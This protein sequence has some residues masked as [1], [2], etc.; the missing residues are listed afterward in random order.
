M[1]VESPPPEEEEDGEPLLEPMT[2]GAWRPAAGERLSNERLR[3]L[4]RAVAVP[5]VLPVRPMEAA[6]ARAAVQELNNLANEPIAEWVQGDVGQGLRLTARGR[7]LSVALLVLR[8]NQQ[9]LLSRF[10]VDFAEDLRLLDRVLVRT[11]ARNQF[12]ARV[13]AVIEGPVQDQVVLDLP[14][15]RRFGALIT[16]NS[17]EMLG[18]RPGIEVVAL[19]K[20]SS[21]AVIGDGALTSCDNHNRLRGTVVDRRG[22]GEHTELTVDLGSGLT[23]VSVLAQPFN[24]AL[25]GKGQI[26]QLAFHPSSVI[27]GIVA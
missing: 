27:I 10:G 7:R 17:A 16:R 19:I 11:S 22:D 23:A 3:W 26:V 24:E 8:R 6:A 2:T 1:N 14:G 4:M 13:H 5:G 21:M 15:Y 25:H 12:M 20:A 9:R 18:L